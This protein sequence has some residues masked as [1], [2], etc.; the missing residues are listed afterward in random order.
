MN[1]YAGGKE[2]N[3]QPTDIHDPDY[4]HKVVDCQWACPAHTLY[5]SISD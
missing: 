4:F 3:L 5:Q 2:S 1:P